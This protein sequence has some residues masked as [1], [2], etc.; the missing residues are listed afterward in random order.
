MAEPPTACMVSMSAPE[1]T[2]EAR[3]TF[4]L[5]RNIVELQVEED[6]EAELLERLHD[7]SGPSA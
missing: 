4:H 2:A 3:G 6:V 7:G 1:S 5:M